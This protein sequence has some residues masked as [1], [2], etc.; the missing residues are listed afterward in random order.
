MNWLPWLPVFILTIIFMIITH[1]L[2]HFLAAKAVGIKV[3][4]FSIGFGPEIVGWDRGET[5]YSIKWI[6]AGGSVRILG[7]NPEEE[8]S[9]EDRP[10]SY[11]Q[12][13]YWRRAVVVLA[14]SF[15]H[16]LI[17]LFLFYLFFWPIGY[18]VPT[19]RIGTVEK[20]VEVSAGKSVPSPAYEAGLRKG[21][22]IVSV[23]GVPVHEWA[24]LTDQLSKNPGRVVYLK[25]KR[26][27]N[28]FSVKTRLLNVG[29]R[30]I[31]GVEV[32]LKDT[33]TRR[34]NP[35]TAAW[36][37]LKT[38]GQ[39]TVLLAKGLGSLFSLKTLKML[40]GITPRTQE[41]PRS[42]IGAAQLAYQAA[43]QNAS[44]FIFILAQLFLFLALFN[45]IPLPPFDGGHLLV[46]IVE[47]LT[48]REIDMRK[49]MPVAWAVVILLT[50]V[51]LRLAVL[52]IIKPLK[53]PFAP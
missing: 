4:Q 47:K 18:R 12:V 9:E 7:M 19:G 43:G 34:S 8:I 50:I 24:D 21:D 23:N 38:C 29:G 13:A 20:T 42:I 26:D 41:S 32:N 49:L 16:I 10:R 35:L 28:V 5:R 2:G 3:E 53:N 40:V 51:A 17:A 11:T 30:G 39:V 52:D 14:G 48:G 36:E 25:V 31:L 33:F 22:L 46:I 37:A 44:V 1:E 27:G 45:L 6:L 15:V